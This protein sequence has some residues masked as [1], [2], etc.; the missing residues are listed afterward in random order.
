MSING[1]WQS[2][3]SDC[4]GSYVLEIGEG[5]DTITHVLFPGRTYCVGR[6]EDC[7]IA[8]YKS[9]VSR[10]HLT[11]QIVAKEGRVNICD[12]HSKNGTLGPS[13][14][15]LTPGDS[16]AFPLPIDLFIDR[17]HLRIKSLSK[18]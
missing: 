15:Y 1:S 9:H 8:V 12:L 4:G 14:G 16:Y 2:T 13:G 18:G 6:G 5:V 3:D 7:D 10:H 11:V 17:T